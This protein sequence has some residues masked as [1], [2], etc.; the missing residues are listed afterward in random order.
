MSDDLMNVEFEVLGLSELDDALAELT[1]IAQ[2]KTL[3][4]ALMKGALPIMKDAKKRAPKDEGDLIK[5]IGRQ[6]IKNADM[7]SVTV[8]I[9]KSRKNPYPFY[10]HFKEY[11]TSKMAATPYLRP[12]FEQNVELAIK[13]FSEELTKRIDKLTQD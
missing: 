8:K 3:E 11:G 4:G 6:R 7:P 10:W 9:K 13:L 5:A 2:K 1:L 12:A